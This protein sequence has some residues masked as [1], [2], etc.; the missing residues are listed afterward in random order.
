MNHRLTITVHPDLYAICRLE[1]Q[2][3][4]PD[5]ATGPS[6]LSITRTKGEL[7]IVC[8]DAGVPDG[9]HAERRRRLRMQV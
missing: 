2:S 1:P 6:F 8:K 4:V 9:T 7:S 3:A 5:W